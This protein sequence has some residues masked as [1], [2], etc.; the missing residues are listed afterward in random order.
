MK[1][2][3]LEI[4]IV[5]NIF[6]RPEIRKQPLMCVHLPVFLF[7]SFSYACR[8]PFISR[9]RH[10]LFVFLLIVEMSST[11]NT[12]VFENK[13]VVKVMAQFLQ[14]KSRNGNLCFLDTAVYISCSASMFS[15]VFT[16]SV[17]VFFFL[18]LSVILQ[19]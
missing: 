8:L 17:S 19:G 4:L 16:L 14:R 7:L 18:T 9:F 13:S 10:H 11:H 3:R 2:T 15:V 6:S 12:L 5:H 1:R